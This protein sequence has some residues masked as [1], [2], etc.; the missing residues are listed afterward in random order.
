MQIP[1]AS[2]VSVRAGLDAFVC[3]SADKKILP[4]LLCLCLR[5]CV[6]VHTYGAIT[7][8][9]QEEG[10]SSFF[11]L[12]LASTRFTCSAFLCLIYRCE[13]AFSIRINPYK[14]KRAKK[15]RDLITDTTET[16][17]APV[18]T[19]W[20]LHIYFREFSFNFEAMRIASRLS[21]FFLHS[22]PH[23][24]ILHTVSLLSTGSL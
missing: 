15:Q 14:F 11:S 8:Q 22:V 7:T 19:L 4:F 3:L 16:C 17:V 13:P 18:S 6:P 21:S 5:S 12:V 10:K 23:Y 20:S 1:S 2:W 24:V 9:A